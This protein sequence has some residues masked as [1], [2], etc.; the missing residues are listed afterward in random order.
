LCASITRRADGE[1]GKR[2]L[3][4]VEQPQHQRV[5]PKLAFV[6]LDTADDREDDG[7]DTERHEDGDSYQE[8]HQQTGDDTVDEYAEQEVEHFFSVGID[9]R[10]FFFLELP[11]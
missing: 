2:P 6:G 4:I 5:F 1:R 11:D 7:D 10:E 3:L 9:L 8:E